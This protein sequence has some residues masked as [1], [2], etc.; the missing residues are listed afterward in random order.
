MPRVT[1]LR[2]RL[3]ALFLVALFA[4]FSPVAGRFESAPDLSGVPALYLYL[5]GVWALI[6]GAAA[7]IAAC[8]RD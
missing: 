2:Q 8:H 6:I 3:L 5:F 7:A 4:F 1:L